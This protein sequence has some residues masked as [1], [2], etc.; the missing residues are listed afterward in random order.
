[1]LKAKA[2]YQKGQGCFRWNKFCHY[3][4]KKRERALKDINIK[5]KCHQLH[6]E[7]ATLVSFVNSH[8][9]GKYFALIKT[10]DFCLK[11]IQKIDKEHA[12]NLNIKF[13]H[14]NLIGKHKKKW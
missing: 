5:A 9:M 4:N 3:C 8:L 12:K 2:F 14:L 7:R 10:G 13:P 6:S 1:M 11:S